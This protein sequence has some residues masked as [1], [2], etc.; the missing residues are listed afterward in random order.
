MKVAYYSPLPPDRTGISEYSELLLP[1]LRRHVDVEV[2]SQK[3]EPR[4]ADAFVYHIGNN[5]EFHDWIVRA[6]RRRPGVVVLHDFVLHHLVAGMTLGS[7][8]GHGY[9]RA[10][11]RE[12][13]LVGRMLGLALLEGRLPPIW[14]TRPEDF[15]LAGEVLD[16]AE[17]LIV[18]SRY[19]EGLAR[20]AGYAGPL[21]RI[22]HPAWAPPGGEPEQRPGSPL[23]GCF[24][25]FNPSKRVPDLLA[26]F[27]RVRERLPD[28]RLVL[29]GGV[30]ARYALPEL[31]DGVDH[32]DYVDEERLWA[33][34]RAADVHVSLRYPTMGET[35]G[36]AVRSLSLG[37]PL[38]VSD[39]GWFSELPDDVALKVPLDAREVEVLAGALELAAGHAEEMGAAARAYAQRELDVDRVAALYAAALTEA[40]AGDAVEDAV[41]REV[42]DAAAFVGIA[43]DD[44]LAAEVA[45]RI[46]P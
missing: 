46:A 36:S 3:S 27:A 4:A 5:P 1:A 29:V 35:S 20:E 18:H 34:M 38:V 31:P 10:M 24:G 9:L 13:G 2:A 41:L 11:E 28:A 39:I 33:L 40:A 6:L 17:G 19:V 7:G 22:P 43:P 14:E 23:I 21:W 37:K 32:V 16:A 25:N 8:D 26:A 45:R 30:S 42:A 44:P 12:E 15:P